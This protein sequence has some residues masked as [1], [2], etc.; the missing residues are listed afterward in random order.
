M[1]KLFFVLL[2]GAAALVSCK[3]DNNNDPVAPTNQPYSNGNAG[4]NWVYEV[5]TQNPTTLDTTTVLDT[6]RV[7]GSD[8]SI[9]SKQYYI[10]AHNNGTHSY[11]N[12]TGNDYYQF[13]NIS[14]PS[15]IDTALEILYLKDNGSV[16]TSWNQVLPVS[17]DLGLPLPVTVNVTFTS[18]IQGTG[19]SRLVNGTTYNDVIY[20]KTTL[21][22][23][24][25]TITSD[26]SN[27]YARNI[28]LI[29]GGYDVDISGFG[30]IHTATKLKYSDPH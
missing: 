21:S 22:A 16:G 7:T 13:Q 10:V 1:K 19:L 25:I 28:G 26:I 15:V 18:T 11:Y 24:G 4:T 30:G 5:K 27:Y 9:G 29:E 17:V 2:C 6:S 12:V 14:I 23:P 8:T 3:K 20:V